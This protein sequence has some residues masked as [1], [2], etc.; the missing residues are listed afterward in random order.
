[1]RGLLR[2]VAAGTVLV[3][4][5]GCGA[6]LSKSSTARSTVPAT[7]G[8]GTSAPT[9]KPTDAF[10]PEKLLGLNPCGLMD[11]AALKP[12]GQPAESRLRDYS[13]CSNYMKDKDG[14]ELNLNLSIGEPTI[15]QPEAGAE[16]DGLPFV[17]SELDDK[18]ACFLTAVTETNPNRGITVQAGRRDKGDL[19]TPGEALLRSVLAKI[20]EDPPRLDLADNTL[21][22]LEPCTLVSDAVITAAV[23]P[24]S[25]KRPSGAHVCSWSGGGRSLM[26]TFRIGPRPDDIADA[27]KSSPVNLGDGVTAQQR[28]EADGK[29]CRVEW[30]HA[31][32]PGDKERAEVVALDL[33]RYGDATAGE[34]LCAKVQA[35]TKALIPR[36][37]KR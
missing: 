5:A 14:K 34:D 28:G 7:S 23:G 35:V 2:L 17:K 27:A 9:P 25:R 37:P 30:A 6:D 22:E 11:D 32:F 36:L 12:L 24:D 8:L 16:I 31:A 15:G 10:D 3:L 29:R 19:C 18:T 1:M 20:R 33:S 13:Q 4:A 26:L 21:V